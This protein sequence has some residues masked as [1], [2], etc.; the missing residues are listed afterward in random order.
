MSARTN[1]AV[2]AIGNE[3]FLVMGGHDADE[4]LPDSYLLNVYSDH[5]EKLLSKWSRKL[6]CW[7]NSAMVNDQSMFTLMRGP[8][9][10][11]RFMVKYDVKQK[12]FSV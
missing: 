1:P 9:Q 5:A 3:N 4:Y 7:A 8:A 11:L 10:N 6:S 12:E 2:V